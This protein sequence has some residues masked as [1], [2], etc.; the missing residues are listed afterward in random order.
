YKDEITA[1][2]KEQTGRTL[3]IDGDIDLSVFPWLGADIGPTR[4]GNAAGFDALH[5]ASMETVEVRVRLMPLLK[6][7]LEID[8]VKLKGLILNLGKDAQ[9]RTNWADLVAATGEEAKP[10]EAEVKE[11][12]TGLED[13]AIGGI[14]ITD[15][16]LVWDDRSTG[17]L[18][19]VN[20]LSLTT[21]E[22]SPGEAFDLDLGFRL[23]A[24]EPAMDGKFSLEGEVLV[25]EGVKAVQ[26]NGARMA[27]DAAGA[28]LPG[29]KLLVNLGSDVALD[30]EKGTLSMPQLKL[31][32]YNLAMTGTVSGTDVNGENPQFKGN[33]VLAGFSPRELI[34]ALGQAVPETAD[35]SALNQADASLDW[36]AS[37][38][39]FNAG[40]VVMHLD[41]TT[42]NGSLG[43]RSFEAPAINF[44]LAVDRINV[45]RYLPPP[46]PEG[47]QDK[48]KAGEAAGSGELPMEALRKLNLD[49]TITVT[50]MTA[51]NMKYRDATL[52]V[53]A[54]DGVVR[55]HP[56]GAKMYQGSYD[57]DI[58]MDVRQSKP[59]LSVNEKISGVQA[60]P[61]LLDLTGNDRLQGKADVTAKFNATGVTPD[62]IKQSVSGQASFAF[63]EGAVRGVNIA[64]LIRNAQAALKGQPAPPG[65][66][67][68]QTDFALLKGTANVTSGLVTND[69]LI[70]QS[71]LLRVTGKGQ[72]H[73]ANETIDY[74]L[75]TKLVGSLEGQGGKSLEELKGVS[76]PVQVGGTYSKPTYRPDL[77][78]ALSDAAKAKVEEKVEEKKEEIQE[79][80]QK[81]IGDKLGDD[82]MKGLFK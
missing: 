69:D 30:L 38:K 54:R 20:D 3:E 51:I 44:K 11:E 73:L 12:G 61:L 82:L 50:E 18:Y 9:G 62:E 40:K 17:S 15:A 65:D 60:G 26:V 57:G 78:A 72:T 25:S 53:R 76:I 66:Q 5:M 71:P 81:K 67:P 56:F 70:L 22:I 33:L 39:H 45:D 14:E 31:N 21:G 59:R 4:L 46:P 27:I 80:I 48:T 34:K 64:S 19:E 55:L 42:I 52:Q 28:G 47:E 37:T 24:S 74:T 36:D 68:D 8:T 32:A 7:K 49:G 79:K 10:K 2:V 43:V 77:S 1:K 63:T 29:G 23:A 35:S 13:L 16:R 58:T 41:D 75:T 6:K